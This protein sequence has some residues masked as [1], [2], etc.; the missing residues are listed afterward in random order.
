MAPQNAQKLGVAIFGLIGVVFAV[1]G[2][3]F[4]VK[5]A[6]L[7]LT[8]ETT[9]G[10]VVEVA[11]KRDSDGDVTYQPTVDFTTVA[12]E[13]VTFTSDVSSS[14]FNYAPGTPV[15]VIYDPS[16]PHDAAIDSVFTV[17]LFPGIFMAFGYGFT[18]I[19]GY[20]VYRERARAALIERLKTSGQRIDATVTEVGQNTSWKVNGRSPYSIYAQAEVNGGVQIFQSENVWFNPSEFV[21]NGQ[22]VSVVYDPTDSKKYYVDISFLPKLNG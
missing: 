3:V 6:T 1:I 16:A 5:S 8:G 12:G 20:M 10:R 14:S 22:T 15:G 4:F 17:W 11:R 2:T 18:G 7:K 13:S 21:K 9:Q 19:A